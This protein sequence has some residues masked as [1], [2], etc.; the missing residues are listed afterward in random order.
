M[1]GCY[2]LPSVEKARELLDANIPVRFI[3]F[4]DDNVH[5]GSRAL[6]AVSMADGRLAPQKTWLSPTPEQLEPMLAETARTA[7]ANGEIVCLVSQSDLPRFLI[8]FASTHETRKLIKSRAQ[9]PQSTMVE[10][11]PS[12]TQSVSSQATATSTPPRRLNV[13]SLCRPR[14]TASLVSCLA[15]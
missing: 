11:I 9:K 14:Q 7:A 13:P 10:S 4:G 8:W 15:T 5:P 1:N 2:E 3:A 6:V 12:Q